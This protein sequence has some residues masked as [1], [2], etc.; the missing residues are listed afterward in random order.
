[1]R[2]RS[3]LGQRAGVQ[4]P[5]VRAAGPWAL[6]G[7]LALAIFAAV[8]IAR[9]AESVLRA[10]GG[11]RSFLVLTAAAIAAAFVLA[12][13]R[14]GPLGGAR[15][16]WLAAAAVAWGAGVY[17]LR[18]NPVEAFHLVEYGAL[19]V[20]AQR[21]FAARVS[22][23]SSYAC[24]AL[25]ALCVGVVDE[26][27]QWLAPSRHWDLRDLAVNAAAG[28]GAQLPL[29]FA[30]RSAAIRGLTP[31]GA[32]RLARLAAA[33]TLLLGASLLN[34]PERIAW[35]AANVPRAAPLATHDDVMV[36]YGHRFDEP[37]VGVWRSRF[38]R[39]ELAALDAARAFDA[40]RALAELP[41]ADGYAAFLARYTPIT[42]P[43]LHEF[44]VHLFRR[45]RYLVTAEW[46]PE[47]VRWYRA[48]LTV[49]LREHRILTR[50]FPRSLAA[51]GGGLAPA[52]EERLERLEL[53]E[54]RYE[55]RV[56]EGVVTRVS[57]RGVAMALA[58]LLCALV[59][60][61]RAAVRR[62]APS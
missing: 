43:F 25:L 53:R 57:E 22:D 23:A 55:S 49:A 31:A 61:E 41:G 26:A 50:Y 39:E 33:A 32:V 6:V 8:P 3:G 12:W 27:L 15:L 10:I 42:D 52:E 17:A 7:A 2:R 62:R 48:D 14:A 51:V 59:L 44:R 40:A 21:A 18:R 9:S 16:A 56:A 28:A 47:D 30:F 46:H 20:A 35:L 5:A 29:A 34:T 36:E 38:T 13:R 54:K 11:E 60:F 37:G 58:A 24:A 4:T 19:G 45:D 1:L